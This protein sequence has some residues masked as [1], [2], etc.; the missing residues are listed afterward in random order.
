MSRMGLKWYLLRIN[1]A[2]QHSMTATGSIADNERIRFAKKAF[3]TMLRVVEAMRATTML[4]SPETAP[5]TRDRSRY[6]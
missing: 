4:R 5:L 2:M 6:F 3:R 1:K